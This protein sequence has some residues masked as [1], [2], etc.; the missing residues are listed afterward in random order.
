MS[1]DRTLLQFEATLGGVQ[2]KQGKSETYSTDPKGAELQISL[3]VKQPVAPRAPRRPWI[4]DKPRPELPAREEGETDAAYN[5]RTKK[6]RE[7]LARW[8]EAD[9]EFRQA[10]A[11]YSAA[12]VSLRDRTL[13]FAQLVG[14]AAVF[15]NKPVTVTIEPADQDILPG[16]QA[17]LLGAAKDGP[18]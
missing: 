12:L 16:F 6:E 14:I 4:T 8:D 5:K 15:G 3:T 17:S 9:G 7:E 18:S 11:A 2:G 10:Q 1:G 13:A